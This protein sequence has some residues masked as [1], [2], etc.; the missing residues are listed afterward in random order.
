MREKLRKKLQNRNANKTLLEEKCR[1]EEYELEKLKMERISN[2]KK[3]QL[4]VPDSIG[5][6]A[7][8]VVRSSTYSENKL[9]YRSCCLHLGRD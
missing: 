5:A 9:A 2:W 8:T 6:V 4:Q 3:L 1:V 7:D